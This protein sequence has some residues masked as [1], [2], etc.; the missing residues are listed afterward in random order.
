MNWFN[1]RLIKK[2]KAIQQNTLDNQFKT[3]A[4]I[5]YSTDFN[6]SGENV[7]KYSSLFDEKVKELQK[8]GR[9]RKNK[10]VAYSNRWFRSNSRIA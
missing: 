10:R 5:D 4:N 1:Y 6:K 9:I 3:S 2:W 8:K 7:N